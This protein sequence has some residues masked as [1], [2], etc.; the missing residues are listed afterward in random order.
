MDKITDTGTEVIV[1]FIQSIEVTIEERIIRNRRA[2]KWMRKYT[3]YP[4]GDE[5]DRLDR[6]ADDLERG[7][8]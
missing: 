7:M 1:N 6:E 4:L 3:N 5:A 8:A 2:A